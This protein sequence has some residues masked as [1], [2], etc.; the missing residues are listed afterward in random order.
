MSMISSGSN[1]KYYEALLAPYVQNRLDNDVRRTLERKAQIDSE[2]GEMLRFE[3]ELAAVV[4]ATRE[5]A[6]I[7]MPSFRVLRRRLGTADAANDQCGRRRQWLDDVARS[8]P[9]W[10]AACLAVIAVGLFVGMASWDR[11]EPN[12]YETLSRGDVLPTTTGSRAY[13]RVVAAEGYTVGMLARELGLS[14]VRGPDSIGS[15]IVS[16]DA[17]GSDAGARLRADQ[18]FALAEPLNSEVSER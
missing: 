1:A 10:V 7:P 6:V 2:I 15:Y 14:V 11:S 13:F 3:L 18:R 16:V 8:R 12:L 5:E 4:K 9:I 17:S